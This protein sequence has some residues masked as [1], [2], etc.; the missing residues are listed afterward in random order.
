MTR[1]I[2]YEIFVLTMVD[3]CTNWIELALIPTA[4]SRT[5]TT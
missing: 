5:V 3:A 4:S 2:T 1:N